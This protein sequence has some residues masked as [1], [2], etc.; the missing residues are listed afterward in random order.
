[1]LSN[2]LDN[3]Y[4]LNQEPQFVNVAGL[5]NTIRLIPVM[6][7]KT[8]SEAID[9]VMPLDVM[10]LDARYRYFDIE[11]ADDS[12]R[13]TETMELTE[14]GELWMLDLFFD[15][16][17]NRPS[18]VAFLKDMAQVEWVVMFETRNHTSYLMGDIGTPLQIKEEAAMSDG[19]GGTNKRSWKI[20]GKALSGANALLGNFLKD[21]DFVMIDG[22]ILVKV[23][24]A[25]FSDGFSNGFNN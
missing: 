15:L 5:M 13:Y 18:A 3:Y 25:A 17:K 4:D 6:W 10:C 11:I 8:V 7:V 1:M 20:S 21:L 22:C 19:R 12:G 2:V 9:G 23:S 14:N 24:Q 16:P